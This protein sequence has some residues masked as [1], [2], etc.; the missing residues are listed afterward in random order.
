MR[1]DAVE[2]LLPADVTT[3]LPLANLSL[4]AA[5]GETLVFGGLP[6]Q[7]GRLRTGRK[8]LIDDPR[9][10]RQNHLPQ[11]FGVGIVFAHRQLAVPNP[12]LERVQLLRVVR[13]PFNIGSHRRAGVAEIEAGSIRHVWVVQHAMQNLQF[14]DALPSV[15]DFGQPRLFLKQFSQKTFGD[16][17]VAVSQQ[18]DEERTAALDLGQTDWQHLTLGTL[19]LGDTPPQ[20]NIGKTTPRSSHSFRSFGKTC[21]TNTSRSACMSRNVEETNTRI[22]RSFGCDSFGSV[23]IASSVIEHSYVL[24]KAYCNR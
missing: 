6:L 3:N 12:L 8:L 9:Q 19:L 5:A 18:A 21:L 2:I 24:A 23:D 4:R 11:R 17:T 22:S 13:F 1:V 15:F 20:I 16:P 14:R 10:I 7:R